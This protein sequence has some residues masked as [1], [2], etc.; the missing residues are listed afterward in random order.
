MYPKTM[1][2][3]YFRHDSDTRDSRNE[4]YA[5]ETVVN[6]RREQDRW[7]EMLNHEATMVIEIKLNN[8][9]IHH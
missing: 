2:V 9:V 5:T 1:T 3:R 7:A 6:N 4:M 8:G